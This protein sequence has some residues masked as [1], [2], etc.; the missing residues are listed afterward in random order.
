MAK[1]NKNLNSRDIKYIKLAYEQA[2]INL[3]STSTNPSV[4]CIIVKN[5]S[6][7]SSGRTALNGRPHAERNA[8]SKKINYKNSDMYL[9]LEPC[10]HYGKTPPCTDKIISKKIKKVIFSITDSDP[11]SAKKAG[12]ILRKSKISIKKYTFKKF[13]KKFY[14]SYFLQSTKQ[15]PFI[16]AKLAISKDFFTINK[17]KK[18]ITNTKSRRLGNFLRSKYD[19]LLTTSKT[20]N[21]DNPLLDCRIQGLERK[22][23]VLIIIDR[24][25]N[26]KKNSKIFIK[27]NRKI[28][29]LTTTKNRSK[30]YFFNTS[31]LALLAL[32]S[33]SDSPSIIKSFIIELN[34]IIDKSF[35]I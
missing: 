10:S 20:I 21:E 15:L 31:S 14:K 33:L 16:D 22:T 3:G 24:F 18:W 17:K 2:S 4:G 26:I 25:F 7:I 1:K 28:Y 12:E 8:L 9:T 34:S 19:C 27:K 5:N 35:G 11:R 6:V 32:F 29:I 23:P 13:A 30:E